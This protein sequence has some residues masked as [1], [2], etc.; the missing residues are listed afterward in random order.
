MGFKLELSRIPIIGA[1]LAIVAGI[2]L[3]LNNLES[4]LGFIDWLIT[5][6]VPAL[7]SQ[8]GDLAIVLAIYLFIRFFGLFEKALDKLS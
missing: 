7:P 3:T 5:K 1:V 6:I 2:V 8:L 4:N